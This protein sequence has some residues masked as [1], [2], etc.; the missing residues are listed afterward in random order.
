MVPIGSRPILWHVM[1]YYAYFGHNEFVLCL[2]YKAGAIKEYFLRY[3][4][5][6]SNDFVLSNGGRDLRLLAS[7]IDDWTITFVD[8]GLNS[9]IGERLLAV[10]EHVAD[11]DM[12]LANYADGVS[13]MW[14]PGLISE[15]VDRPD[16][17]ASFMAVAP[18]L[19]FHITEFDERGVVSSISPIRTS[20]LW[21]NAGYF[22][23][24]SE[25]FDYLK[26]G[27]EL[28]VEA[29]QRL[30]RE[31]RLLAHPHDGYWGVMDTFKDKQALD[32]AYEKGPAP[33]ELWKR[34]QRPSTK[35][36]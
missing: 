35:T 24:R 31:H 7:D 14:L 30:A 26:P 21:V 15:L 1:K 29:F 25:I 6:A 23:L 27:E 5:A 32:E 4:E 28:V 13:D 2:G 8:T 12:F 18:P 22:A 16:A 34:Q 17:V 33:W 3:S 10:R 20:G 11:E 36:S 19:S 9:N